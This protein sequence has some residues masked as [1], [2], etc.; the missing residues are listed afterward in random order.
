VFKEKERRVG[1]RKKGLAKADQNC[2]IPDSSNPKGSFSC[3]AKKRK[4]S[5]LDP[6]LEEGGHGEGK[7]YCATKEATER[8]SLQVKKEESQRKRGENR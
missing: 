8:G 4:R 2:G 5:E 7:G 3:Q 6:K 1:C